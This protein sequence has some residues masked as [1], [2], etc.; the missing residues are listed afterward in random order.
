MLAKVS[1]D[2]NDNISLDN[3]KKQCDVIFPHPEVEHVKLIVSVISY[4]LNSLKT[5]T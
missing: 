2:I 4:C 1:A 5:D 3:H